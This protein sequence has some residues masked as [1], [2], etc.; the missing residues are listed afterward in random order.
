MWQGQPVGLQL[1][2]AQQQQVQVDWPRRVS[3]ARE[4]APQLGLDVL[5]DVQQLGGLR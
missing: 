1:D 4:V 5:A 2:V 3:G